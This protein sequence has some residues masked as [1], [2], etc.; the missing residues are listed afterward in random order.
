M[1]DTSCE[2]WKVDK[3]VFRKEN[4]WKV[5]EKKGKCKFFGRKKRKGSFGGFDDKEVGV[6]DSQFKPQLETDNEEFEFSMQSTQVR[7][8]M[9]F[10]YLFECLSYDVMVV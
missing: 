2:E 10:L 8:I 6:L 9:V 7:V 5:R 4:V 1:I 3:V